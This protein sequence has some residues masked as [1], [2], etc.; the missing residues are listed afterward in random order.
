MMYMMLS[1]A[2]PF[3]GMSDHQ[4]LAK[5]KVGQYRLHGALWDPVSEEGKDLIRKTLV[6]S[7]DDRIKAESALEHPWFQRQ[8]VDA[9]ETGQLDPGIVQNLRSFGAASRFKQ[10]ALIAVAHQLQEKEVDDLRK[11]FISI[12]K[13]G[14]GSITLDEMRTAL[15][16]HP[17]LVSDSE[18][19]QLMCEMDVNHDGNVSY[20]EFLASAMDQ[21]I[22]D[23]DDL[24]WMAFKAFDLD[25]DGVI[26]LGELREVLK[27]DAEEYGA[28]ADE[29]FKQM[30]SNGTGRVNFQ[31]FKAMVKFD[32]ASTAM[33]ASDAA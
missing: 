18:L 8:A 17:E 3:T 9:E 26:K 13:D 16:A 33:S 23:R 15:R 31:Q 22:Q 4:V 14:D 32:A 2:P 6:M 10:A 27:D 24:V 30:D 1:G 25:N 19:D 12:D 7:Q 29:V 11:A 21:R 28:I 5:V 20:T